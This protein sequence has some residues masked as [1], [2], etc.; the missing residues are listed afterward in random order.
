MRNVRGW[1]AIAIAALLLI[2]FLDRFVLVEFLARRIGLS[3]LAAAANAIAITGAGFLARRFQRGLALNFAVGYPI[4]GTA[5]FLVGTVKVNTL[6]MALTLMAFAIPGAIALWREGRI[7][8]EAPADSPG[9][10][11]PTGWD[12]FGWVAIAVVFVCGFVAA[13]APPSSLDE[14]SYHLAIPHT[15]VSEGRAIELPLI[16]HSYFPLGIESA[17]L[18][19]IAFLGPLAGGIASHLLHLLAAIVATALLRR[20]SRSVFVTAAIVA[21]PALALT[22]GWSLVDWPLLAICL[23]FLDDDE[24]TRIA[25]L[26]AGL[27]T[28]YTFLPFAV[29]AIAI[30]RRWRGLWPGLIAGSVFFVRNLMLTGNPIAPFLSANA[31][32]VGGYRTLTLASYIFDGRLIDESLGAALFALLPMIAGPLAIALL[33]TGALLWT[34][35]PSARLLVPYFG[36]AATA[37]RV[38]ESRVLRA[39]I[40]LAIACQLLL[41][42]YFVNRTSVFPLIAATTTD[43]EFLTRARPSFEKAAWIDAALPAESRTLVVGLNETY[44]FSHRVRGGGN[45]DGPRLSDYLDLPTPEALRERLRRD[46]ITHVAVLSAPLQ[47]NVAQKLEERQTRLSPGAQRSLAQTLDR[48]A[49]TVN[50]RNGDVLFTL[51]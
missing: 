5:C 1:V 27:L 38:G 18:P 20:R 11:M 8:S 24:P 41:V 40:A 45:F 25:A 28:K 15:W 46:G 26:A 43:E 16:S 42:A 9:D 2:T 31:P 49:S 44:W 3:L 7:R 17:D 37:S 47:T 19:S 36:V 6:T 22:A 29:V 35:A 32:H 4:F 50:S 23:S 21:T 10:G 48:F 33:V 39:I 34:T 13:Q 30:T 51:K 14:L 12:T